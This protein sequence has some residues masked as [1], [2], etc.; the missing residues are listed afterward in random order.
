MTGAATARNIGDTQECADRRPYETSR[1]TGLKDAAGFP[2]RHPYPVGVGVRALPTKPRPDHHEWKPIDS[3]ETTMSDKHVTGPIQVF[4]IGFDHFQATGAIMAQL[5]RVRKRGVIRIVDVLFVQK[6]KH[7]SIENSM[8]LTDLSEGERQRLGAIAG[9]LIGLSE[10]GLQA[11]IIGAELG[12]ELVAE[13]DAGLSVDRLAEL[14]ASIPNGSAAAI[15]VIEHHWAADLRDAIGEAGGR[16]LMQAMITP[17]ALALVGDELRA[18]HEAEEA[19]EAAEE[20]KMAAAIEIAQ[21]LAARDLIEEAAISEAADVVAT[22]IAI[23]DAAAEDV[24]ETLLAAEL[25][26]EAAREEATDVVRMAMDVEEEATEEAEDAVA[27]SDKIVAAAAL[28]AIRALIAEEV[29][30]EE[31]AERAVA[32]LVTAEIIEEEAAEEAL[33]TVLAAEEVEAE[34]D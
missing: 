24:I 23:E 27:M 4:V 31:A 1:S 15:L 20:I 10:G 16:S 33:A 32:A 28:R 19:I 12:A 3:K 29:I 26:E 21:V 11:G 14:G 17:Q 5:R 22:A 25:I 6:D 13:R 7:G 8:H 34:A 2:G 30:E 9:G 18:Q